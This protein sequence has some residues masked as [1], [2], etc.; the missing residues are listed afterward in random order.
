MEA[1]E[2][3]YHLSHG[4][5]FL[6]EPLLSAVGLTGM[7]MAAQQ[8]L[9]GTFQCPEGTD[10]IIRLLIQLLKRP[11]AVNMVDITI[12]HKTYQQYWR[13]AREQTSSSLSGLH[14]SHWKAAA[15]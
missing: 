1:I 5:P 15:E 11:D 13:R 10:E 12:T 7:S 3:R 4:S 8:I 14:F 2:A 6:N 9:D